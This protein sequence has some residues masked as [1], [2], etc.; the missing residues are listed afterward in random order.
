MHC[1][2]DGTASK[3]VKML[4]S[5]AEL[6]QPIRRRDVS[7]SAAVKAQFFFEGWYIL[8]FDR[9]ASFINKIKTVVFTYPKFYQKCDV[10]ELGNQMALG[11]GTSAFYRGGQWAHCACK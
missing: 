5:T 9:R 7:T 10:V 4:P 3:C 1:A 8:V 6:Q 11:S 2:F